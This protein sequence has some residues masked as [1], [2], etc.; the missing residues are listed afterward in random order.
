VK[1]LWSE[2]PHPRATSAIDWR[3]GA[4]GSVSEPVISASFAARVEY[5]PW[6]PTTYHLG[7]D[8]LLLELMMTVRL[9][10][11]DASDANL[12]AIRVH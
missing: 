5:D 8:G 2:K 11:L 7:V 4:T 6:H 9:A 10:S 12:V 3:E 1:W